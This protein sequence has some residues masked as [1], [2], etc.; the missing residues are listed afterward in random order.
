MGQHERHG[1][2]PDTFLMDEVD[3]V[4]LYVGRVMLEPVQRGFLLP[5]VIL[6][7]PVVSEP[8][9][10]GKGRT[11]APRFGVRLVR[12]PCLPEPPPEVIDDLLGHIDRKRRQLI[13]Q[14]KAS[15]NAVTRHGKVGR[16]VHLSRHADGDWKLALR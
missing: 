1:G 6:V 10:V 15:F 8:L 11:V 16:H 12:P 5:P 14:H 7:E 2:R 4:S 9:H 13:G 3:R